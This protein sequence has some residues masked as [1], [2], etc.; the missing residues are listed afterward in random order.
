MA[1]PRGIF[2]N[3][4]IMEHTEASRQAAASA[5]SKRKTQP[6]A[7]A[8]RQTGTGSLCAPTLAAQRGDWGQLRHELRH[9]EIVRSS[10]RS[11]L[12]CVG[13]SCMR[14]GVQAQ[15]QG[16]ASTIPIKPSRVRAAFQLHFFFFTCSRHHPVFDNFCFL[17]VAL[18]L[19]ALVLDEAPPLPSEFPVY[20]SPAG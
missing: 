10:G 3:K 6:S 16:E 18:L 19:L 7:H 20:L 13:R 12:P 5:A 1:K 4:F 2:K 11:E 9:P 8:E 15:V 14:A 17:K